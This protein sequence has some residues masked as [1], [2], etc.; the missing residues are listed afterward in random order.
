MI[1]EEARN[2]SEAVDLR[3][4]IRLRDGQP[5]AQ[6]AAETV[7]QEGRGAALGRGPGQELTTCICCWEISNGID[8]GQYRANAEVVSRGRVKVCIIKRE[9]VR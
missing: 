2:G 6:E 7:P 8:L 3:V 4:M 1:A 5:A 9:G